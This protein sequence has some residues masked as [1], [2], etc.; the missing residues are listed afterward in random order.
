MITIGPVSTLKEAKL[1]LYGMG[2]FF[3]LVDKTRQR[4][5]IID[6]FL[7]LFLILSVLLSLDALWQFHSGADILGNKLE[8]GRV[9]ALFSNPNLLG[10][11]LAGIAP[12]HVYFI[13]IR[14]SL[15]AKI[16]LSFLMVLNL[17]AIILSGCRSAWIGILCLLLFWLIYNPKRLVSLGYAGLFVLLILPFINFEMIKSR[18]V[19]TINLTGDRLIIWENTMSL[20]RENPLLGTGIDSFKDVS[21]AVIYNG[22]KWIYSGP[23]N[24]FL[25]VWQT[26]G[27][28]AFAL[29]LY[30]IYKIVMI[31]APYLKERGVHVFLFF[32]WALIFISAVINIPFFSRYL[33]F[34][35]WLILGLL[36]GSLNFPL[37]KT[38]NA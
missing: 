15:P 6:R 32:S 35:L 30:F 1:F 22:E 4:K 31:N 27:I 38:V 25:E 2:L 18:Y 8:Y 20:I 9:S 34:Y 5:I 24:F 11:F 12:L 26:S 28:I 19:K 23:H 7:L 37:K 29:F 3:V 14:K 21:P 36:F 13:E 16:L 10:F 17:M 33:N